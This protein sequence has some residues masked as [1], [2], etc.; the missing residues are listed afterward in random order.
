MVMYA[1][2]LKRGD[3]LSWNKEYFP[4]HVMDSEE[5]KENIIEIKQNYD[6]T[7]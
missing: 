6:E 3:S 7:P 2:V 4:V 1:G 5:D